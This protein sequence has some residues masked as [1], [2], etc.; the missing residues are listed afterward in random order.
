MDAPATTVRS[1]TR[2]ARP[3]VGTPSEASM[4]AMATPPDQGA[5][6]GRACGLFVTATSTTLPCGAPFA[7]S[8]RASTVLPALPSSH[9]TTKPVEVATS[10]GSTDCA[11]VGATA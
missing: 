2:Y 8:E 1:G 11:G 7:S 10:A 6:T 3:T 5:I 9:A 4:Y